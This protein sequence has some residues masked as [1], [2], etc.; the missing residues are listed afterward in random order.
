MKAFLVKIQE[1]FKSLGLASQLGITL[2]LSLAMLAGVYG[3]SQDESDAKSDSS[4][5]STN[6]CASKFVNSF[7]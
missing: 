7:K 3:I 4:R 6:K 2:G 5:R 1:G